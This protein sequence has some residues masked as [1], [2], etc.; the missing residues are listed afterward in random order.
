MSEVHGVAQETRKRRNLLGA[1]VGAALW[2]FLTVV[3]AGCGDPAPPPPRASASALGAGPPA[4]CVSS[5]AELD[6]AFGT[7]RNTFPFHEQTVALSE[8]FG[9]GCRVLIVSEPPPDVSREGL[10]AQMPA[11]ANFESRRHAIGQDGWTTDLLAIIPPSD[12]KGIDALVKRLHRQ[13]F[14][15]DYKAYYTKIGVTPPGASGLDVSISPGELSSWVHQA[16]AKFTPLAGGTPVSLSELESTAAKGGSTVYSVSNARLIAWALPKA[17]SLDREK[18][19]ARIFALD[20]DVIL[21]A[22]LEHDTILL[23]ARE[24][25]TSIEQVPPLRFE[26]LASLA[27]S[28][29]KGLGQSYERNNPIA[30]PGRDGQDWAPI[31]LSRELID[32]EFGSLLNIADQLLKSWSNN[33]LTSYAGFEYP[34]PLT[35]PADKP[36]PH[37]FDSVTYNFNTKGAA[38]VVDAGNGSE[39]IW[40]SSTGCLPV[41]Y[42]PENG[43]DNAQVSARE[44][45]AHDHFRKQ[46][47]PLLVR[48][49]Q[50]SALYQIFKYTNVSFTRRGTLPSMDSA[51][52]VM[53]EATLKA[54]QAAERGDK[55]DLTGVTKLFGDAQRPSAYATEIHAALV[56]KSD[57]ALRIIASVL[58]DRNSDSVS[59]PAGTN[60]AMAE[61]E[62]SKPL[63]LL[64]GVHGRVLAGFYK[65]IDS[66]RASYV[67]KAGSRAE[68]TI[69]T[70][71]YI[72]SS[73]VGELSGGTGGHNLYSE[74]PRAKVGEALPGSGLQSFKSLDEV[75]L[76]Q[77]GTL[78]KRSA[79]LASQLVTPLEVAPGLPRGLRDAY[80]TGP[81]G[82]LE[83]TVQKSGDKF[84]VFGHG[85]SKVEVA[86]R[87]D[88][89][90]AV[91]AELASSE[92]LVIVKAKG[93]SDDEVRGLVNSAEAA[94]RRVAIGVTSD[95]SPRFVERIEMSTA[96]FTQD[97]KA[98]ILADGSVEVGVKVAVQ[99][100]GKPGWFARIR[101]FLSKTAVGK[102]GRR[103]AEV[104]DL[105]IA[106]V[107]ARFGSRDASLTEIAI[108]LRRE[109]RRVDPSVGVKALHSDDDITY[110]ATDFIIG[111]DTSQVAD[112]LDEHVGH[113]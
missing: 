49:V 104:V 88:L 91:S 45:Q 84:T 38:A 16:E 108:E 19:N 20:S 51:N 94:N 111:K 105:A 66:V 3:V 37:D 64:M 9:E 62:A 14:G 26:M 35:W 53:M 2:L 42:F 103:A 99:P 60:M 22:I 83:L 12:A 7:F 48:V 109:L 34:R 98:R 44:M 18:V 29:E 25:E 31:Y 27:A 8:P 107:R 17:A 87:K 15:T 90:D 101:I 6:K 52:A 86:N 21:G 40:V 89:T 106:K 50:Y 68:A 71:S 112:R 47:D 113:G 28:D 92:G 67:K 97:A 5:R 65:D 100:Q 93:M 56:G 46:D 70:P 82:R 61:A 24:R 41:S 13:L 74:L 69:R 4:A 76:G 54:L 95:V 1:M 32:T 80:S 36:L 96:T 78:I 11:N 102:L 75:G 58:A 55:P 85:G 39:I 79:P 59:L 30:G 43:A 33:G 77:H 81:L 73:N 63:K 72:R 110:N 23:L 57:A 10:Q